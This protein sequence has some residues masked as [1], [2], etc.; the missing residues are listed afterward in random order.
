M[1]KIVNRF[2]SGLKFERRSGRRRGVE[3]NRLNDG[4]GWRGRGSNF[5][6]G[7]CGLVACQLG[8]VVHELTHEYQIWRYDGPLL[9]DLIVGVVHC[10]V[11]S[12]HQIGDY[13]GG[14]SGDARLT[15]HQNFLIF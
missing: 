6:F 8:A 1:F 2:A 9:L 4:C 12:T 10:Q 7:L 15:M 11:E 3:F 13:D 5:N 14:R